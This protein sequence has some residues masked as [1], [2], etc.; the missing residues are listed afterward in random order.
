MSQEPILQIPEHIAALP[1]EEQGPALVKEIHDRRYAEGIAAGV[2]AIRSSLQAA[3]DSIPTDSHLA[4]G[5]QMC[6]ETI[7][8]IQMEALRVRG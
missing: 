2:E 7:E 3:L 5:A 4:A 1:E 8:R 6:V